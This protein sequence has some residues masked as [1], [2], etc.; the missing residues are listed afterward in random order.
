M[1]HIKDVIIYD[2]GTTKVYIN[3]CHRNFKW[4]KKKRKTE[5]YAVR[6]NDKTGLAHYIGGIEW[7]G[8]WRQYVFDPEPSTI[9]NWSCLHQI[10][11]FLATINLKH[12]RKLIKAK[13]DKDH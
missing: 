9:W 1:A 13:K 2:N 5:S 8:R 6:R 11:S 12:R 10:S 4:E 7:S 3:Q